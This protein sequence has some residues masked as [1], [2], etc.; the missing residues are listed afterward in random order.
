MVSSDRTITPI[1]IYVDM[2]KGSTVLTKEDPRTW[3][4]NPV[5]SP[6]VP[7]DRLSIAFSR[8]RPRATRRIRADH[9]L[10]LC[11]CRFDGL[12]HVAQRLSAVFG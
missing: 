9:S 7:I 1:L 11:L 12:V 2:N 6:R 8:T 4:L 10:V 5:R 3:L